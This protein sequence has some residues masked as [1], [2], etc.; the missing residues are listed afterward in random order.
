MSYTLPFTPYEDD[1][2]ARPAE[3]A[4]LDDV[5]PPFDRQL[6]TPSPEYLALIE[7][8]QLRDDLNCARAAKNVAFKLWQDAGSDGNRD[9]H[10]SRFFRYCQRVREIDAMLHEREVNTLCRED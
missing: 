4:L 1:A 7:E 5:T 10:R 3:A 6:G 8:M 2:P 9:A